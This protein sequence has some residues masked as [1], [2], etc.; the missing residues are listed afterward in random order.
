MDSILFFYFV[1]IGV[2]VYGLT[3]G[4]KWAIPQVKG[5]GLG[6]LLRSL[7]VLFG[8]GIGAIPGLYPSDTPYGLGIL[9]GGAAGVF[10][11]YAY[12]MANGAIQQKKGAAL[13]PPKSGGTI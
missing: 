10:C 4:T 13:S 12:E 3:E 6:I 7:P 9:L 11:A 2:V 5:V 1:G 8:A